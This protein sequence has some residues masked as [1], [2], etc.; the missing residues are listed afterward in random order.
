MPEPYVVRPFRVAAGEA[1]ASQYVLSVGV[2]PP[3]LA[4]IVLLICR[5]NP[6]GVVV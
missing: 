2:Y 4:R 3:S 5:S 6:F 1:K